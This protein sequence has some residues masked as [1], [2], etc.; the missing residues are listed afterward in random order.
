MKNTYLISTDRK[1]IGFHCIY[2]FP[3]NYGASVIRYNETIPYYQG[4]YEV[5]LILFE[6]TTNH[7]ELVTHVSFNGGLDS[8]VRVLNREEVHDYLKRIKD[9]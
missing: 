5:G 4:S 6:P 3:N 7:Y 2:R 1:S 8:V 9:L